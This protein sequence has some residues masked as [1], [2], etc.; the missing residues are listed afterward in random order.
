MGDYNL[1]NARILPVCTKI[2]LVEFRKWTNSDGKTIEAK[3][4]KF[5]NE[6]S[7]KKMGL[8]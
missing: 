6:L 3:F 1:N 7:I 8:L 4:I 5:E 2:A